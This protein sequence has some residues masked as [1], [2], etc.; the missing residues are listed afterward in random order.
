[1]TAKQTLLS[2]F[3]TMTKQ[4][5]AVIAGFPEAEARKTR[6][7]MSMSPLQMVEHLC[8]CIQAYK[9]P[10]RRTYFWGS[11]KLA[12][13]TVTGALTALNTER[14]A[15]RAFIEGTSDEKL[16]EE[17]FDYLMSHDAYH[18]GQLAACRMASDPAWDSMSL[19]H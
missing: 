10:D 18:V 13:D 6:E 1:M 11:Y 5:N 8:D 16:L 14:T 15:V 9:A 7:G 2:Q 17:S 12:D 4:L 19:Y 3:D